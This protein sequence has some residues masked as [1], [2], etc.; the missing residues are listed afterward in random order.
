MTRFKICCIRD[1]R[2]LELAVEHGASAVGLVSAMPSG[3]GPIDEAAIARLLP[4]VPP[5]VTSFLLTS[6][7]DP[8]ALIDQ[9]RRLPADA[10]QLVDRL[11][12]GAHARLRAGLPGVRLV[13]VL[14]VEGPEAVDEARRLAGRV[15]AF[16][17]DSG[18]PGL[19]LKELG[20]TG[21]VHD[22]AI[23][24][25]VVGAVDRPVFLA[26]GLRPDN[27]ADAIA[28][29]APYAVDVCTGVRTDGVLDP[30]RLAAFARAVP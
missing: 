8:E 16:L 26:G 3:P 15:D 17:L 9:H 20:G 1:E 10:L 30:D 4:R 24:R 2:E 22:W 23:S 7:T 18:R 21:R 5:G 25:R 11:P 29:V 12:D 13:Q 19:A 28:R 14:H 6:L 27:V